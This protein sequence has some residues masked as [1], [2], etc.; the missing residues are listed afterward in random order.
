MARTVIDQSMIIKINNAYLRLRTYAAVAREL[1]ISP[2][3]V[4]KYVIKDYQP[5]KNENIKKFDYDEYISRTHI[6]FNIKEDLSN[7]LVLTS[8]EKEE[9]EELWKELSI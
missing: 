2:S 6:P 1:G 7:E 4:S 8:E 5:I 9:L 3:T